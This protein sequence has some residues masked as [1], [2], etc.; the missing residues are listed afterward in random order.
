MRQAFPCRGC[1]VNTPIDPMTADLKPGESMALTVGLAQVLRGEDPMPTI[2][3]VCVLALAR[4]DGRVND[5]Y[6]VPDDR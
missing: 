5:D 2:A 6:E 1:R 4:I 3:T